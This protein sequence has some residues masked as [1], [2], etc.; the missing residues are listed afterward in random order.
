MLEGEDSCNALHAG[1][2]DAMVTPRRVPRAV[3]LTSPQQLPADRVL[4]ARA[5]AAALS[6]SCVR[7]GYLAA[8]LARAG[9]QS[10]YPHRPASGGSSSTCGGLPKYSVAAAAVRAAAAQSVATGSEESRC[11]TPP[12]HLVG[13]QIVK[14]CCAEVELLVPTSEV[15]VV[16]AP[17]SEPMPSEPS[18]NEWATDYE[19]ASDDGHASED[20]PA[21]EL[22]GA[23]RTLCSIVISHPTEHEAISDELLAD[24]YDVVVKRTFISV[25]PRRKVLPHSASAPGCLG[26]ISEAGR[27]IS[28]PRRQRSSRRRSRRR[29]TGAGTE[30]AA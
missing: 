12:R 20:V 7:V 8:A 27:V 25:V 13:A 15:A 23:S 17:N 30:Q 11:R 1:A 14:E 29:R 28:R 9:G 6:S 5:A 2:D 24:V 16:V 26:I 10:G 18:D 22:D 21:R 4:A 19:A 3:V